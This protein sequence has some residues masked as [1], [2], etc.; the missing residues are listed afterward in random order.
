M[1][2]LS[3]NRDETVFD[4][5]EEFDIG[6]EPGPHV[7]FGGLGTHFCLGA[8]LAKLELTVMLSELYSRV[9]DLTVTGEPARLRS[10]FFH[11]IKA[12]PCTTKG[13]A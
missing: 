10:A 9:P 13:A 2:Y 3:A 12:L 7:A 5:A 8:Q 4:R 11:G 1:H 6:R